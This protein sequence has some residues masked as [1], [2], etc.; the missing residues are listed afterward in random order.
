M[1][2]GAIARS[3]ATSNGMYVRRAVRWAE[4]HNVF[5]RA[6]DEVA[7]FLGWLGLAVI[8]ALAISTVKVTIRLQV[9]DLQIRLTASRALQT[10]LQGEHDTLNQ[11]IAE[12]SSS[13]R[14]EEVARQSLGMVWPAPG[15]EQ[16][17]P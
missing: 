6:Q 2:P 15:Q 7:S 3:G 12:L 9:Q 16:A 1:L 11:R 10:K 4:P 17:M 13:H 14:I 5:K 8:A